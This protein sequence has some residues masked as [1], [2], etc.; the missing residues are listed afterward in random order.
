MNNAIIK[1]KKIRNKS[2]KV[3]T[4]SG[5]LSLANS[6]ELKKNLLKH[7]QDVNSIEIIGSEIT[8]FDIATVQILIATKLELE[9]QHKEI[10]MKLDL[11]E[12]FTSLLNNAGIKLNEL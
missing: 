2:E 5:D 12:N 9:T 3:I 8:N 1:T 10:R 11:P 6:N 4:I 7:I